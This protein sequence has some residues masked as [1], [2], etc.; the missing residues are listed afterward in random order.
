MNT[1]VSFPRRLVVASLFLVLTVFAGYGQA[2][3]IFQ[4]VAPRSGP[5]DFGIV[6]N[7]PNL[8][9]NLESYQAG[10]GIKL[11]LQHVDLRCLFDLV[12][13]GS[14]GSFGGEVGLAVESH[15]TPDPVS[16][17]WGG[18]AGAGYLGQPGGMSIFS[19]EIGAIAGV[20]VSPYEFV[21]FFVEYGL[22]AAVMVTSTGPGSTPVVD[23]LADIGMGNDARIGVVFYFMRTAKKK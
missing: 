21:S 18:T 14:A 1:H 22:T 19:T 17:Y 5:V 15:L 8:L 20:E 23:F 13:N 2:Q 3:S 11:G 6:F 4:K 9:L 16:F 10:L 7:M 12:V